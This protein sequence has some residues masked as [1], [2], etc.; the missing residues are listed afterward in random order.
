M[1]L[2]I[3]ISAGDPSGDIHAARLMKKLK[4]KTG[5][6]CTFIGI[7]GSKM[8]EEGLE[9]LADIKEISVVGFWEVA[10]KYKFFSALLKRSKKLMKDNKTDIF[11]P[12][13]YPGFN[14]KLASYARS[15]N[16]PVA[17]YIA[18]QLWAWGKNR[19]EKL[20]DA[21]NKV[22]VVFPFEV[23]HFQNYGLDTEFVGHPLLELP[24]FSKPVKS[25]EERER[26]I[27]MLPGSRKQEIIRH[28]DLFIKIAT[29]IQAER[30]DIKIKIARSDNVDTEHY[31]P[32]E[33]E[34]KNIELSDNSIELMQNS[35]AGIVKTGTSNLEAALCGLP[36]V[37]T[38]KTSTFTYLLGKKL[39]NLPYLSIINILHYRNIVDE[40]IQKDATPQK[41]GN[42]ILNFIDNKDEFD[43]IQNYMINIREKLGNKIASENAAN[44]IL[45]LLN[46]KNEAQT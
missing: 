34:Q 6:N 27:A 10:K 37:M 36:F 33:L 18:P 12:V 4:D 46:Y 1:P 44:S 23:E 39:I 24:E 35:L 40:F 2:K 28:M 19:A 32:D 41:I 22:L 43:K 13:D 3:F 16:I 42:A 14:I 38:Y 29:Y 8:K 21:V 26:T 15:I 9:S 31:L 5:N 45:K 11:I 25:F 7:G 17:Y 20:V 30:Q